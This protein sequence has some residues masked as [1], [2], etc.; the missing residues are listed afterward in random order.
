MTKTDKRKLTKQ[1]VAIIKLLYA[2][3]FSTTESMRTALEDTVSIRAI[4]KRLTVLCERG[5]VCKRSAEGIG[6]SAYYCLDKL[7]IEYLRQVDGYNPL[8]LRNI[9]HDVQ[10]SNRFARHCVGVFDAANE[11]Q[12]H[13]G[14]QCHIQT[15]S[16]FYGNEDYPNPLPDAYVRVNDANG[17]INKQFLFEYVD[18]TK[19][20]RI[21]KQRIESLV[22]YLE[23][24]EWC[25]TDK[26]PALLFICSTARIER[27]VQHWLPQII[28]DNYAE[29]IQV[30]TATVES[31]TLAITGIAESKAQVMHPDSD[32]SS[33]PLVWTGY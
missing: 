17:D 24:G 30:F 23:E 18:N 33:R 9:R 3:R 15:R 19:P 31:A 25:I 29:D 6:Q 5:Y 2:L 21:W 14:S 13:F 7:G 8:A 28:E 12:N 27:Y 32:E 10:A 1:Q 22:K 4:R 16:S 26:D 20:H 11:I